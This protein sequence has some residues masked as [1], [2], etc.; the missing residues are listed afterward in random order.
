MTET[1]R[2]PAAAAPGVPTETPT[3]L[4]WL[5]ALLRPIRS[6]RLRYLPL[7]LVYFAYGAS[8]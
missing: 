3:Q 2:S 7:I 6:F 8:G 5:A 4:A 1:V